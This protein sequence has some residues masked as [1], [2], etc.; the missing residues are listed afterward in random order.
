MIERINIVMKIDYE[1]IEKLVAPKIEGYHFRFFE[2]GDEDLW[3]YVTFKAGEFESEAK[4][5]TAFK[6]RFE[7]NLEAFKNRC[8]FLCNEQGEAIGTGTAWFLDGKSLLHY[9]AII[10]S[11]QGLG[12]GRWLVIETTRLF[13]K[14]QPQRDVYLKT[15]TTSYQAINLYADLG[16]YLL[17]NE[18]YF[19][20]PNNIEAALEVLEN[21]FSQDRITHL[22]NTAQRASD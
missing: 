22:R 9:I 3:A 17:K 7:P 19:N 18:V 1:M 11:Y 14:L 2:A 12:L 5:R 13:L 8:L 20:Q 15:Q 10:K 4:A 6:K 16:Y 21:Y